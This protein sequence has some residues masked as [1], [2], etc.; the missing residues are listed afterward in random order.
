MVGWMDGWMGGQSFESKY[1]V[2][3]NFEGREIWLSWDLY[4]RTAKYICDF[5]KMGD[6]T[7]LAYIYRE[8]VCVCACVCVV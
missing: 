3:Q 2:G 5:A 6:M 7:E 1:F 8:C 4:T